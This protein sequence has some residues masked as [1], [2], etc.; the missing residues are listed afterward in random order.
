M[1]L[2][3]FNLQYKSEAQKAARPRIFFFP[4][5][6]YC[7]FIASGQMP[8]LVQPVFIPVR[9]HSTPANYPGRLCL[10]LLRPIAPSTLPICFFLIDLFPSPFGQPHRWAWICP[11]RA[12]N[13]ET[14]KSKNTG[15]WIRVLMVVPHCGSF[16]STPKTRKAG[17]FLIARLTAVLSGAP[18]FFF[19]DYVIGIMEDY[20]GL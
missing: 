17:S 19:E 10:C 12:Y 2:R 14:L 15:V 5:V 9:K 16:H 18:A 7:V 20:G 13:R 6:K 3:I 1:I 4:S 11:G 8:V